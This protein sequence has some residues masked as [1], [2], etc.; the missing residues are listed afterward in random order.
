MPLNP[1]THKPWWKTSG[2]PVHKPARENTEWRKFINSQAWRRLAKLHLDKNPYCVRHLKRD[3]Y[4]PATQ[5]HHTKGQDMEHAFDEETLESLCVSCHSSVTM[6]E[7][8]RGKT[9]E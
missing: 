3:E 6:S 7:R 1:P 2:V 9:T 5:V 4:V 8:H